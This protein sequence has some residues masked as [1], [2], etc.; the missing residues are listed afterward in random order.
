[1]TLERYPDHITNISPRSEKRGIKNETLEQLFR[2]AEV[3]ESQFDRRR[4]ID[5]GKSG[6]IWIAS[7]ESIPERICMKTIH[8]E[9]KSANTL[10]REYELQSRFYDAGVRVPMPMAFSRWWKKEGSVN[11]HIAMEFLEGQDLS[12]LISDMLSHSVKISSQEWLR[13][14]QDLSKQIKIANN[15]GLYHRDLD[16]R[17]V[18]IVGEERVV[19]IIDFGDAKETV[20]HD[21]HE[22]YETAGRNMPRDGEIVP[23]INK[24]VLK[25]K[26]LT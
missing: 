26:V 2:N 22:I 18:F 15:V 14:T 17:N 23:Y 7:D 24:L 10:E 9:G 12:S 19:Y 25:A 4:H 11:E 21:E 3:L 6:E 16:P 5:Q 1:M 20:S 13:I 8:S